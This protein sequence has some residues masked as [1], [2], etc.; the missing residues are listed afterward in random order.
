MCYVESTLVIIEREEVP[1]M[2]DIFSAAIAF[3][4]LIYVLFLFYSLTDLIRI[5]RGEPHALVGVPCR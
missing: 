2:T 1:P 5:G 3:R 4:G